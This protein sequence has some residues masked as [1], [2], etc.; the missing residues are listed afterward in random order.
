MSCPICG[1]KPMNCDCSKAERDMYEEL[2]E[3]R[4]EVQELRDE[5]NRMKNLADNAEFE[6][7]LKAEVEV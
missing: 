2:D 5:L 4:A 7:R 3:L 1:N 6:R